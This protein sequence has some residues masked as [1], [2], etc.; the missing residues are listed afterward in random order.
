MAKVTT[1]ANEPRRPQGGVPLPT[2]KRGGKGFLRDVKL[3]LRNISWPT[4]QETFRLT[5]VVLGVCVLITVILT[6]LSYLF[7]TIINLLTKGSV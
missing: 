3:E 6:V 1:G 2:M 7:E 4:R 5:G